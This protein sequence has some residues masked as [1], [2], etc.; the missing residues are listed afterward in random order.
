VRCGLAEGVRS[1]D[2][3]HAVNLVATPGRQTS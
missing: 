3:A 2:D 1:K